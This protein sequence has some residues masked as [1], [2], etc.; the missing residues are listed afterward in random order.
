MRHGAGEIE[1]TDDGD[2]VDADFFSAL[3]E[4]AIAAAFGGEIDDYRTGS[5]AGDHFLGD[6]NGSGFAGDDGGRDDGVTFGSNFA[7]EYALGAVG[8]F[9]LE[10]GAAGRGFRA[11]CFA[12]WRAVAACQTFD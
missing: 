8:I 1:P 2:A 11:F 9:S 6:E 12:R 5:H 3:G 7:E 10:A 4:F